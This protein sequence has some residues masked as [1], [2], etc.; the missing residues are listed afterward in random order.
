[1]NY[2]DSCLY[3][4]RQVFLIFS[5]LSHP[6]NRCHFQYIIQVITTTKTHSR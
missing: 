2:G 5:L 3:G 4:I 6:P 1:M